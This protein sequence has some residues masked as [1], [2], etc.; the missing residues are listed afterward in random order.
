MSTYFIVIGLKIVK[1]IE[2]GNSPSESAV[3]LPESAVEL[4]ES[5]V[6]LPS[7]NT[8]IFNHVFNF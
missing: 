8:L 3:E 1:N 6:E 2:V 4:P 5:A 7:D